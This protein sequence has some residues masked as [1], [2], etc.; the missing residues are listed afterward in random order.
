MNVLLYVIIYPILA[1]ALFFISNW[2]GK[3]SYSL[4]YHKIDFIVDREDSA[5]FNFSLKVLT[6]AIFIYFNIC[7]S[8]IV[9]NSIDSQKVF[10]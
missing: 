6:P 1:I 10:T 2:L 7:N 5:A 4:G 3:H 8:F 9:F